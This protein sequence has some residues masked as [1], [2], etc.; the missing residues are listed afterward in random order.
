VVV[1]A[2]TVSAQVRGL[3]RSGHTSSVSSGLHYVLTSAILDG[4]GNTIVGGKL[5]SAGNATLFGFVAK[6]DVQ[7]KDLWEYRLATPQTG[8]A[9]SLAVDSLGNVFVTIKVEATN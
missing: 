2:T 3:W 5:V 1:C 8:G 9:E 4:E 6:F 7:G